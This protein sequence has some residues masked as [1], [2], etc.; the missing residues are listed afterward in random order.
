LEQ[1]NEAKG[2]RPTLSKSKV[3]R[4]GVFQQISKMKQNEA[5]PSKIVQDRSKTNIFL[6]DCEE[7]RK[8]TKNEASFF[9]NK[10]KENEYNR[11]STIEDL[12]L[13]LGIILPPFI[14]LSFSSLCMADRGFSCITNARRRGQF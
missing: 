4:I 2:I 8:R 13:L 1:R 3:K 12:P 11:S 10:A 7:E 5:K 6:S 14:N 9:W